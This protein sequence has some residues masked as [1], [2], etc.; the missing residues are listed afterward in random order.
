MKADE[1][2][3]RFLVRKQFNDL[4][5]IQ[6]IIGLINIVNNNYHEKELSIGT[7]SEKVT[8]ERYVESFNR[9]EKEQ[10]Y[11]LTLIDDSMLCFYY[12]FNEKG[13]IVKHELSFLPSYRIEDGSGEYYDEVPPFELFKKIRN[14]VRVDFD[15]VGYKEYIHSR[16]H[17]HFGTEKSN[18]IRIPVE[19]VVLPYEFLFFVLKYIYR[20]D[21]NELSSLQCDHRRESKLTNNER[22]KLKLLFCDCL[23]AQAEEESN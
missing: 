2:T 19:H 22:S 12:E 14:Y 20:I 5:L 11:T 15:E 16:I 7:K 4:F 3:E 23:L 21:D 17:A 1:H 8:P 6:Q 9:M 13:Q 18:E 10:T